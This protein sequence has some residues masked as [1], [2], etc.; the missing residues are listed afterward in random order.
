MRQP[1]QENRQDPFSAIVPQLLGEI[2][3][4]AAE[5]AEYNKWTINTIFARQ[6]KYCATQCVSFKLGSELSNDEKNCIN[7]C[8]TKY[9]NA[10]KSY[11]QESGIFEANMKD[12][13]ARGIDIFSARQI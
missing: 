7:T 4:N 6:H 5:Q 3:L 8:F 13:E 1:G 2:H 9:A 11:Q 10:L 12:L